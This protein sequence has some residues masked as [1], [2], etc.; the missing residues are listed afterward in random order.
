MI[1]DYKL[2]LVKKPAKELWLLIIDQPVWIA[3]PLEREGDHLIELKL[4]Y[5]LQGGYIAPLGQDYI[6]A[7]GF[8]KMLKFFSF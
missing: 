6:V 7:M 1:F 3:G 8:Y 2:K 5:L 4:W